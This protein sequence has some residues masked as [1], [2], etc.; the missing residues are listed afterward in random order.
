[1]NRKVYILFVCKD[2]ALLSQLAE[3]MIKLY[4]SDEIVAF[5][6][7]VNPAKKL[8][9]RAVFLMERLGYSEMLQHTTKS[10]SEAPDFH[11]DFVITLGTPEFIHQVEADKRLEW[12]LPEVQFLSIEELARLRDMLLTKVLNLAIRLAA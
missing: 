7:G 6:A 10:V 11:Y 3:A 4:R 1:M 8:D 5:S 9:E 12:R 2:N